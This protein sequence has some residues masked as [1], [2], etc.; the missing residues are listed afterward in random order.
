MKANDSSAGRIAA[1]GSVHTS[2]NSTLTPGC[3][4]QTLPA[5]QLVRPR[6]CA[7]VSPILAKLAPW[8]TLGRSESLVAAASN[9]RTLTVPVVV[10]LLFQNSWIPATQIGIMSDASANN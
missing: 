9:V 8:F 3:C 7:I 2:S 6:A 5:T 4:E 1:A 10:P